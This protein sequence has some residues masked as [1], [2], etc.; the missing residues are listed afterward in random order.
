M[1]FASFKAMIESPRAPTSAPSG[2][3]GKPWI[4]PTYTS[5]GTSFNK[6]K[7]LPEH[8]RQTL[9]QAAKEQAAEE[10][11]TLSSNLDGAEGAVVRLETRL[12]AFAS[13][14]ENH[15]V[16]QQAASI[17]IKTRLQALGLVA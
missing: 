1:E 16:G 3:A 4:P 11:R 12:S 8:E 9:I 5:R 13:D 10:R 7:G 6:A 2:A 15:V 17:L 14:F